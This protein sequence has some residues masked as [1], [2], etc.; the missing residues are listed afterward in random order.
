MLIIVSVLVVVGVI[1][2]VRIAMTLSARRSPADEAARTERVTATLRLAGFDEAM[3]TELRSS[4]YNVQIPGMERRQFTYDEVQRMA[5]DGLVTTTTV[6][7]RTETD[8]TVTA[9]NLPGVFSRKSKLTTILLGVFIG[10][11]GADR[12]Y[13]GHIWI[14]ILKLLTLGGLGIWSIVDIVLAATG[15]LRDKNG[16]PLS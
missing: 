5:V 2:I 10:G 7:R 15:R 13:L 12:F 8:V 11:F 16:L 6:L 4:H 3:L 9:G 14:G 1:L